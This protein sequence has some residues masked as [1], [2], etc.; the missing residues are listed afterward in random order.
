MSQKRKCHQNG[1]EES[2]AQTPKEKE[3]SEVDIILVQETDYLK[4]KIIYAKSHHSFLVHD[5]DNNNAIY[6]YHEDRI[7]RI[8]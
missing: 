3:S 5:P 7:F 4:M 6:C 1:V 8:Y 2:V